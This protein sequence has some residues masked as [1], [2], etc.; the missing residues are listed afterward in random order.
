METKN[1]GEMLALYKS[2]IDAEVPGWFY[3]ADIALIYV[4]MAA[5]TQS[6]I[7]GDIC[8]VGVYLGKSAILLSRLRGANENF[9]MF[10]LFGMQPDQQEV[11]GAATFAV[12][13]ATAATSLCQGRFLGTGPCDATF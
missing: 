9:Y 3:P 7:E 2:Q 8:E 1:L 5:Q 12:L 13:F 6:K 4:L 11:A 10:D